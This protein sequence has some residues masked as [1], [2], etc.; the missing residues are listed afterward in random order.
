M[1]SLCTAQV[2]QNG[3]RQGKFGSAQPQGGGG[4]RLGMP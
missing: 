4:M 1:G 2:P 3:E